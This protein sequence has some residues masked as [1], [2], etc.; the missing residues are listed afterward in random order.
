L[1][2]RLRLRN[3]DTPTSEE[4]EKEL[5]KKKKKGEA[6]PRYLPPFWKEC[7]LHHDMYAYAMA[8]CRFYDDTRR[9]WIH[10]SS[11]EAHPAQT[12]FGT[13][14]NIRAK[15]NKQAYMVLSG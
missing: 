13:Y 6:E 4:K 2:P 7:N 3:E 5:E 8:S 12:R 9:H 1:L 15:H 14:L 11:P 10:E